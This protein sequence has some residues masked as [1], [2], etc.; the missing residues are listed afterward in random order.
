MSCVD[1]AR[2]ATCSRSTVGSSVAN[3]VRATGPAQTDLISIVT[4][5]DAGILVDIAQVLVMKVL[6]AKVST[7]EPLP[8]SATMSVLEVWDSESS[9]YTRLLPRQ[10]S[11]L[12]EFSAL[13]SSRFAYLKDEMNP[14]RF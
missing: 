3:E 10:A 8:L 14:K 2:T 7:E 9:G 1:K 11:T 12:L 6:S 13:A 5:T 4:S